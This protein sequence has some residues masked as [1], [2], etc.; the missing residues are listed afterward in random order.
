MQFLR[1]GFAAFHN[2]SRHIPST[3]SVGIAAIKFL[4]ELETLITV[5]VL[6]L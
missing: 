3:L 1:S 2:R 6:D 5:S 4:G